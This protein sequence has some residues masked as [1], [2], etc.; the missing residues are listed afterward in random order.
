MNTPNRREFLGLTASL[1]AVA[2]MAG[3]ARLHADSEAAPGPVR[4][5]ITTQDKKFQ[6]IESPP[7]WKAGSEVSPLGIQLDPGARYQELIGFGGAFTDASCYLMNRMAPEA[8]H[9]LLADLYGPAGLGL[10]VGRTCIGSSDYSTELYSYDDGPEDPELQRFTIDHDRPY[11]LPTLRE[12]REINPD[13]YLFSCVWSPP[14]WMKA[15]G[16]MLGGS[17]RER[18]FDPLAQYFVKF[19]QG[20]ADAGVKVQAVTVNNEVDTD[21]DGHFPA[22]LWGQELEMRFVRDHLAPALQKAALNTKIWILDHN[23]DL[24]GR[25]VDELSNPSVSQ[26]VDGVAWHSYAGTPDAMTRIHDMFPTKHMYFTEGGPLRPDFVEPR[27]PYGTGWARWSNAFTDMLRNWA[28]M[29]CVWNLLLDENSRPDIT[30]P[31]R[32]SRPGGLVCVDTNSQQLSYSGNYYAFAHFSKLMQR[33]AHIFAS[34]GDLPGI[35]HVAAENTDG[36]RVLV[37]TNSD[38]SREQPVQCTLG[39]STLDLVLPPDS[40]TSLLWS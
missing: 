31:P 28:R 10:S 35:N 7:Q 38:S 5:W 23:Y 17:I 29:I 14:G 13:L 16:S 40:I 2:A 18:W 32:P 27:P 15:G 21:Q 6:P 8:R 25:A 39:P 19:L 34:S 22:T 9:A 1:G 20:Y 26:Y 30:T 24:W 3:T 12:A 33:G 37:L 11:L 36:S 4:A